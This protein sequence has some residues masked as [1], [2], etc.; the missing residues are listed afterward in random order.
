MINSTKSTNHAKHADW[1]IIIITQNNK[2]QQPV[3]CYKKKNCYYGTLVKFFLQQQRYCNSVVLDIPALLTFNF[4]SE[5][6][7]LKK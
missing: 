1:C 6:I 4:F 5:T 3:L 7:D 2:T